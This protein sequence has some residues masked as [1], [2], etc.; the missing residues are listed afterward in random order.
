MSRKLKWPVLDAKTKGLIHGADYNPEQW[1]DYPGIW[2]EDMRLMQ[3][4]GMNSA[5][6]GIFS[7]A[8]LE[9]EEGVYDWS[10]LDAIMDRLQAIGSRVVLATP[11]G[12]RPAWMSQKYPEVLRTSAQDIRNLHGQRHNHCFT[13]PV[14]RQKCVAI[15]T[16]L[17]QRYKD[18][19]ALFMWHVSNEY[20]GE[21]HCELCKQAFREWLKL[22]Y[23]DSLEELNHAWWTT[24]W[25]HT[26]TDWQQIDPPSW[27]G[28]TCVHGQNLDW[29][30]FVTHQTVDFFKAES[31]PLRDITPGVPVVINMM[32]T[33]PGLDY[34]QFAKEVDVVTWD[35]YS[36]WHADFASNENIGDYTGFVHD[37]NR[38]LKGG[39][40]F[41]MME[42]TPSLVNWQDVCKLKRPGMHGLSSIQ[43]V[44]HGS[45]SVQYFQWRK[46]R[47]SSEKFH[48]AVV[49]HEGSEHTR[50]FQEVAALGEELK[51]LGEVAGSTQ[52]AKVA[53]IFDW[54]NRWA[55]EDV[56][57]LHRHKRQ[58]QETCEYC[59]R[60]FRYRGLAVDLIREECDFSGYKIVVA[61]MLYMVKPGVAERLHAFVEAGGTLVC[62]YL[63]GYADQN[64]LCFLG[65]FPG[66]GLRQTLGIWAE[67]IDTLYNGDSNTVLPSAAARQEFGFAESG[68]VETFCELIHAET[69]EVLATYGSDFYAGRPVLTRNK[70]GRGVAY[71]LAAR[72]DFGFLDT[73]LAGLA[74]QAGLECPLAGATGPVSGARLPAGVNVQTRTDGSTNWYFVMNFG[75]QPASLPVTATNLADVLRPGTKVGQ[76]IELAP[77]GYRVLRGPAGQS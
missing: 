62:T 73:L 16:R 60:P 4:A 67:E 38:S 1:K 72:T 40:P 76:R 3:L 29:K 42:S 64:D 58:Y 26:Y 70:V 25:S 7:W 2:D 10:W 53:V 32:G 52:D 33:F 44:A 18:H 39:Q 20:S 9:P 71:Y 51:L 65:G 28:E 15:N 24:F 23:H 31:A 50:V 22:K 19:P 49:D 14:Y 8:K 63:T 12:A 27:R 69:A 61:P 66:A 68:R 36:M 45:D 54:E 43:A 30:R 17:A 35:N 41:M 59:H 21:C 6:V 48:G 46:S 57:G 11:S 55:I 56:Q 5:S 13:S 74:R 77:Y 34:W 75:D 47:G 37:I